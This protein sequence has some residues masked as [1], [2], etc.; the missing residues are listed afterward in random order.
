VLP[1]RTS[2][3]CRQSRGDQLAAARRILGSA[4]DLAYI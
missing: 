1:C 4:G 3:L 2:P